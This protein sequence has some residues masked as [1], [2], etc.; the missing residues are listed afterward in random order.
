MTIALAP[1]VEVNGQYLRRMDGRP[2][3]THD[4]A[5]DTEV[6][7]GFVELVWLPGGVAGRWSFTALYN[8]VAAS[9]PVFT[10]RQGETGL[11]E[12]YRAGALGVTTCSPAICG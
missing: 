6:D 8:H 7:M 9:A 12:S 3:F 1:T 5:T 10:L 2:F 11:L 4:A